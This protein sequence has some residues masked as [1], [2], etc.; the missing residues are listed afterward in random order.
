MA[1]RFRQAI[2]DGQFLLT[3]EVT[4]PKGGDPTHMLAVA[5]QLRDRVHAVNITDGSRAV[6]R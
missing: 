6:M 1:N 5:D 4:P 3:A 2:Q